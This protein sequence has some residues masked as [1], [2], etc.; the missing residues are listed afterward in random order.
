[1]S[2][3]LAKTPPAYN[4][5]VL[6]PCDPI[7]LLVVLFSIAGTG[8]PD[9][10]LI[11]STPLCSDSATSSFKIVPFPKASWICSRLFCSRG[12]GGMSGGHS[13]PLPAVNIHQVQNIIASA[14]LQGC[15]IL[16]FCLLWRR[17]EYDELGHL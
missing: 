7:P 1:M 10:R 5:S 14:H 2:Q 3:P 9:T 17:E 11:K 12:K 4:S 13:E 15:C 8:Q 6:C 16:S